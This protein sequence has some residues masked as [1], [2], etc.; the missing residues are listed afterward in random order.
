[1]ACNAD[2]VQFI[3]DQCSGAGEIAVKKMMGDYCIYCD[4]VLFGLICDNNLYLKVTEPGKALL[5]EVILRP[6]YDGAK[7]YFYISGVDDRD[8]LVALIGATLPAL[9]KP[10][11]KKN[12]FR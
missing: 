12:P 11:V 10:K 4:G 6:P 9:P 1:M 7:D 3:V 2:F 8:F 5:V